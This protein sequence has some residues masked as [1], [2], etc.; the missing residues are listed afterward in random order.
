[1][2]ETKGISPTLLTLLLALIVTI[3]LLIFVIAM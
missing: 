2:P 1:L 3:L